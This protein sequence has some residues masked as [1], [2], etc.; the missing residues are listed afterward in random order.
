MAI[1]RF[2]SSAHT[3]ETLYVTRSEFPDFFLL[4]ETTSESEN[5]PRTE[6]DIT[7]VPEHEAEEWMLRPGVKLL[8]LLYPE[9]PQTEREVVRGDETSRHTSDKSSTGSNHDEY[10][11]IPI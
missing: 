3:I 4:G 5:E 6:W 8:A 7:P 2:Q 10:A 9:L 1:A 11:D